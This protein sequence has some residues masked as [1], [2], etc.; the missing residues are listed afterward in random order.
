MN[1]PIFYV[2]LGIFVLTLGA[3][4][5]LFVLPA[6]A[7]APGPAQNA[8]TTPTGQNGNGGGSTVASI[9]DL[10]A[11]S[12]PTRG[13][14]IS[15]P[16]TITGSA[17]GFWYFEASFPVELR[18]AQGTVIAQHYAE[19]QGEWMTENFVPFKSTLSFPAQPKGSQGTLILRKDNPSGLP[20]H[21]R[22][23]EIPVVF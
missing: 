20:E 16:L 10:I 18:N 7:E 4:I 12:T 8:T 14:Q 5:A 3:G 21:D 6:P 2:L 15:S 22:S 23:L 9:P 17:R 19:A 1:K 13:A 11:V